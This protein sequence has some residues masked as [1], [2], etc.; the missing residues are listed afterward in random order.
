MINDGRSGKVIFLVH[1]ILNSNSICIGPK[2]P[3]IW[4]A[5]INEVV[6]LLMNNKIGI[7]QLPCPEQLAFGLVRNKTS[8]E[9]VDTPDFRAY[10]RKLA[11]NAV[12]LIEEYIKNGFKVIGF[13]GKRG[14]PTCSVSTRRKGVLIEEL[15]KVMVK[16]KIEVLLMDFERTKVE[17]CLNKL[18]NAIQA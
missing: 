10:C 4:P 2:T 14:S 11:E 17:Q 5:M 3:S 16:R 13:L 18:K 7:I 6:E 1:C 9:E 12:D 8:R 15:I